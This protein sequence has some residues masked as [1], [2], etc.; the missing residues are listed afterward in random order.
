MGYGEGIPSPA[1]ISHCCS[2]SLGNR[3]IRVDVADQAQDKGERPAEDTDGAGSGFRESGQGPSP[4]PAMFPSL[5]LPLCVSLAPSRPGRSLLRQRPGSLPG[6]R[7][8]RER[9]ARA[10]SCS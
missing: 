10:S 5:L 4:D 6:L 1:L 3:R 7:A 9:L 8:V 2:Q